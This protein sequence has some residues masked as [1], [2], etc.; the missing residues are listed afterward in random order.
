MMDREWAGSRHAE[1]LTPARL[2][3]DDSR[4]T[5]NTA[6]EPIQTG[7][8]LVP[9]H[10]RTSGTLHLG[11]PSPQVCGAAWWAECEVHGSSIDPIVVSCESRAF[12]KGSKVGRSRTLADSS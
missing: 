1:S 6:P 2:T 7:R 3:S 8:L 5:A 11:A 12:S 10:G 9:W 4:R